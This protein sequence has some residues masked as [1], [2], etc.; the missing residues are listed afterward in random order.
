VIERRLEVI[1]HANLLLWFIERLE[2]P[3]PCDEQPPQNVQ[4]GWEPSSGGYSFTARIWQNHSWWLQS[5]G[6][7]RA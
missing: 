6:I 7:G 2:H 4:T 5:N 1:A 3:C